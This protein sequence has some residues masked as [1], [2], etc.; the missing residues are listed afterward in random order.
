[1]RSERKKSIDKRGDFI[2]RADQMPILMWSDMWSAL[3]RTSCRSRCFLGGRTEGMRHGP[4]SL[5][6]I[7]V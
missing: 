2:S 7:N 4:R 5:K 3:T 1:M 6:R